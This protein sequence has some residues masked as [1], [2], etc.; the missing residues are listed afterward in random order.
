MTE[1]NIKEMNSISITRSEAT[2]LVEL[3]VNCSYEIF[4]KYDSMGELFARMSLDPSMGALLK[5]KGDPDN[6]V[7][8]SAMFFD[9]INELFD[10][11][12][13]ETFQKT[14]TRIRTTF[15]K[16]LDKLESLK[17][18]TFLSCAIH[19][20]IH[21]NQVN[22]QEILG[23][24]TF[25]Y[26]DC[27]VCEWCGQDYFYYTTTYGLNKPV[28]SKC[29]FVEEPEVTEDDEAEV[30]EDDESEVTED[31]E[32]EV[33]ED[34]ESE[35]TE[36]DEAEVTEDDEAEVT[37]DDEAELTE[38]EDDEAEVTEAELTEDDEAEVTEDDEAE[39]TEAENLQRENLQ[40]EAWEYQFN[41][42]WEKG[43]KAAMK[44]IKLF[45]KQQRKDVRKHMKTGSA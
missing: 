36:D 3:Y 45:A 22:I 20:N 21:M 13:I 16:H 43:W 4:R 32:A 2:E 31:D 37:E 25:E 28:C 34:D 5:L 41:K 35:V 33:T 10:N 24:N 23:D 18:V 9:T 42:G 17:I 12:G 44:N 19:N 6:H 30:T 15:M 26:N 27:V 7:K 38:A 40:R 11:V 14:Q 29:V 39:V 8:T 1:T